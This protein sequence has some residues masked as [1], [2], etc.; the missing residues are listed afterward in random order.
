MLA[1]QIILSV[2]YDTE[3]EILEVE[4]RNRWVYRYSE[5]PRTIFDEL[6]AAPSHGKYLKQHI[7]DTYDT[8]RIL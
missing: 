7:V 6:L 2:G 8:V 3:M 1:S 4:F 5:V